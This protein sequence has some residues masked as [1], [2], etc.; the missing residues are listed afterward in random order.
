MSNLVYPYLGDFKSYKVRFN[1]TNYALIS[2]DFI[3]NSYLYV[4]SILTLSIGEDAFKRSEAAGI[5]LAFV[6]EDYFNLKYLFTDNNK[7][8]EEF[9]E[10]IEKNTGIELRKQKK[11]YLEKRHEYDIEGEYEDEIISFS[12]KFRTNNSL[13]NGI[14]SKRHCIAIEVPY[15]LFKQTENNKIEEI[16]IVDVQYKAVIFNFKFLFEIEAGFWK[17]KKFAIGDTYVS[18]H[19]YN[20]FESVYIEPSGFFPDK[21]QIEYYYRARSI[22]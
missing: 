12:S 14:D 10:L 8:F 18:F 21:D 3:S 6:E 17:K 5:K 16:K 11:Y 7:F 9:K 20:N 4:N 2:F 22:F 1:N 19:Y 13:A 15:P